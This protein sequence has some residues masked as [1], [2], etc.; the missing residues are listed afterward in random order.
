MA[1][2]RSKQLASILASVSASMLIV[3]GMRRSV[4][5]RLNRIERLTTSEPGHSADV[6]PDIREVSGLA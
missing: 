3:V 6:R 4:I 5:V 1:A 2:P